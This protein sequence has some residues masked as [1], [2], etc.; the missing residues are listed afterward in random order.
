MNKIGSHNSWSY[1]P[2]KQWYIPA[3]VCKCQ[4]ID[5]KEQY[6]RGVRVFDLRVRRYKGNWYT[7][8]GSACFLT[9][10]LSDLRWLNTQDDIVSVRVLL[11]YNSIPKDFHNIAPL[12]KELCKYL[13]A[14]FMN[15]NFFGG[16]LK[17]TWEILYTFNGKEIQ[18]LDKY[19][20][21]TSLFNIKNNLLRIIDD[22]CPWIY[23]KLYNK[24]NYKEYMKHRHLE[25]LFIDFIDFVI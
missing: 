15:I 17:C 1:A 24:K 13:E 16:R 18:L 12:F 3:F 19:S 8:H 11:E 7:A 4:N 5:I 10:F 22:W 25:C 14:N 9:D 23:A 21:T 2:I 20:S 6:I